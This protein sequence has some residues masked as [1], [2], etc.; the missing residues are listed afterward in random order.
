M[1]TGGWKWDTKTSMEVQKRVTRVMG[2][3]ERQEAPLF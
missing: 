2:L 3:G 1:N